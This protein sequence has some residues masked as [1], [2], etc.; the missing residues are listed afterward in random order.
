[1]I[2]GGRKEV[3]GASTGTLMEGKPPLLDVAL[4]APSVNVNQGKL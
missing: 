1:M 3:A 2:S 4:L